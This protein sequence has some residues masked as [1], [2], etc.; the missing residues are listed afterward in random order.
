[1]FTDFPPP[2]LRSSHAAIT[3]DA[4]RRGRLYRVVNRLARVMTMRAT[5]AFSL[6]LTCLRPVFAEVV[7]AGA[8]GALCLGLPFL[9]EASSD[10]S[11]TTSAL[12]AL[13]RALRA[14]LESRPGKTLA[15][16]LDDAHA[17]ASRAAPPPLDGLLSPALAAAAGG[18]VVGPALGLCLAF[19][20]GLPR[21][22]VS[23]AAKA[24][25]CDASLLLSGHPSGHLS[26]LLGG[27]RGGCALNDG[28]LVPEAAAA[29][30]AASP[31][32]AEAAV[33]VGALAPGG[34]ATVMWAVRWAGL[35]GEALAAAVCYALL[36]H[37][38]AF[39]VAAHCRLR[40]QFPNATV[41]D[42]VA[43]T[44]AETARR[45]WA[46]LRARAGADAAPRACRIGGDASAKDDDGVAGDVNGGGGGGADDDDD[47][48]DNDNKATHDDNDDDVDVDDNEDEGALALPLGPYALELLLGRP[49]LLCW[50]V[51]AVVGPT[52]SWAIFAIAHAGVAASVLLDAY[53]SVLLP[54]LRCF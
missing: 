45:G 22:A 6:L 28:C 39:D 48:S 8:V 5:V 11:A 52:L 25:R 42:E 30:S 40:A 9:L 43:S 20:G 53:D 21:L 32:V 51:A 27:G 4:L 26:G 44:L 37:A 38:A 35:V 54:R 15:A 1:V 19:G 41:A 36:A 17:M 3:A 46:T 14:L 18:L 23:L 50:S 34:C 33:A 13:L 12:L 47:D 29:A 31:V 16:A 24:L 7:A 49:L 10:F 2:P